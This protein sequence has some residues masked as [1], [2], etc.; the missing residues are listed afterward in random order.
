MAKYEGTDIDNLKWMYIVWFE[1]WREILRI[2]TTDIYRKTT[3]KMSITRNG[4]RWEEMWVNEDYKT[5]TDTI[6]QFAM[7][8]DDWLWINNQLNKW[9]CLRKQNGLLLFDFFWF[10]GYRNAHFCFIILQTGTILSISI[11][12]TRIEWPYQK[13]AILDV[14]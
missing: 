4:S 14:K 3:I 10:F 5:N 6:V 1:E 9:K 2:K 8:Y 11:D 12:Y 13:W 7:L